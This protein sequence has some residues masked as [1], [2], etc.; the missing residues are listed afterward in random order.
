MAYKGDLDLDKDTY[1]TK[2]HINYK[3][4]SEFND[5]YSQISDIF[6]RAAFFTF[7]LL[8]NFL[9]FMIN[10]EKPLVLRW[11]FMIMKGIFKDVACE[12]PKR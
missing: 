3:R 11:F 1:F 5:H 8:M 6:K 4:I 12:N 10:N 2:Y 7:I 9:F